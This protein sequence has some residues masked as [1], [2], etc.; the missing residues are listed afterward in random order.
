M[1]TDISEELNASIYKVDNK[2]NILAVMRT[3]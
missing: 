2:P 3:Q 1:F